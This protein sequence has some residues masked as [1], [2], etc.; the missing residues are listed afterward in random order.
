MLTVGDTFPAFKTRACVGS[1][2]DSL[3]DVSNEA[4]AGNWAVYFFYPKDFTFVCPTEIRGREKAKRAAAQLIPS[5]V[6]RLASSCRGKVRPTE[7]RR[8]LAKFHSHCD[9]RSSY[10]P[11][12]IE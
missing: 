4:F 11:T 1:N 8:G 2:K 3:Q 12:P 7:W 5:N 10:W 6:R 9:P